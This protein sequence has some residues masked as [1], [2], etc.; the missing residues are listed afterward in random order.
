[1]LLKMNKNEKF[2]KN[3]I[4]HAFFKV[5]KYSKGQ[6]ILLS[7]PAK[8]SAPTSKTSPETLKPIIKSN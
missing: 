6:A 8:L 5:Q 4:A 1:M 2:A 7:T 3:I